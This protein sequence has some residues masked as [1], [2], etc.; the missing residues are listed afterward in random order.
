MDD[1]E[2]RLTALQEQLEAIQAKVAD[3]FPLLPIDSE[4]QDLVR[5]NSLLKQKY[6]QLATQVLT[7]V[8]PG[9]QLDRAIDLL[10]ESYLLA[11]R[12]LL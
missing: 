4:S 10:E 3:R 9:P 6:R 1:K 7:R 11:W 2:G 12:A 8:P 5:S